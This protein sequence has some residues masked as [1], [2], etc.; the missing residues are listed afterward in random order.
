MS[1][2][3]Q[4]IKGLKENQKNDRKK[5]NDFDGSIVDII[6]SRQTKDLVVG[7]CGLIGSGVKAVADSVEENLS[8]LG[9]EV[10]RLRVSKL[11]V[12]GFPEGDEGCCSSLGPFERYNEL[13]KLGDRL[14][15]LYGKNILAECAINEI[16]VGKGVDSSSSAEGKAQVKKKAYLIDQLK[17]PG[18][19]EILRMV[20]QN[21]FY[22]IGV[23]RDEEER[24]RNLRD[25]GISDSQVDVL[26]HQDRRSSESDG[27]QTQK[28]I[29][30]ADFFIKNNQSHRQQLLTKVS[31]FIKLIHGVNGITPAGVEKG[32]YAAFSASL[33]SA[34]LSRQVGAAV[35]D[36]DG[37]LLAMGRN[38]VPKAGGGLYTSDDGDQDH[39]CINKGGKCYNDFRKGKIRDEIERILEA[40]GAKGVE[41]SSLADELYN[42]TPISSLIEYSRSI[43]AE[44]DA[45]VSL[46]RSSSS[47]SKGAVIYTTTFPCHNC[48]RHIVAAGIDKVV[49][50]EPYD[51]SLALDLHDD[52]VSKGLDESK[53]IFEPFEGVSPR[54]Y[55]KFFFPAGERKD[56]KGKALS[57]T[58]SN[59]N[60]IDIQYLDSYQTFETKVASVFNEKVSVSE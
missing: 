9:Y 7:F 33:Q 55:Q 1:A 8:I 17:N 51:K 49:Y 28:A 18:E 6:S 54:R 21:N 23:L 10:V 41:L 43:H 57:S 15:G 2:L 60:H 27:Q 24:K 29:L 42:K 53:V 30:D 45:I 48:A 56:N 59:D 44:M 22:L 37:N 26:I 47:S 4:G 19:V 39:R 3:P 50:I 36:M 20:Y 31:R 13:Q 25:E 52:A 38:D 40:S 32:M 14:R 12:S 5:S 34:C 11:M 16:R 58:V 46:A 35:F